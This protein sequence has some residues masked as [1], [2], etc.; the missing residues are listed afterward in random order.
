[1]DTLENRTPQT[2]RKRTRL[3]REQ[4]PKLLLRH[5]PGELGDEEPERRALGVLLPIAG[6]GTPLESS[7]QFAPPADH[8]EQTTETPEVLLM[9]GAEHSFVM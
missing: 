2:K 1:M 8:W 6:L 7:S 5:G 4:I 3:P 9:L